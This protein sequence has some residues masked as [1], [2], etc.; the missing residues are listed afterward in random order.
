MDSSCTLNKSKFGTF[1]LH[2][3]SNLQ[4]VSEP[5][6]VSYKDGSGVEV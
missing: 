1:K 2:M 5:L 6:S 4:T 3:P